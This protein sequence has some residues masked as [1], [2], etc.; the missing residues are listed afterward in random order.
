MSRAASDVQRNSLWGVPVRKLDGDTVWL[1]PEEAMAYAERRYSSGAPRYEVRP[2]P[3][4]PWR[5]E[6]HELS[7]PKD[8]NNPTSCAISVEEMRANVG[9]VKAAVVED[10]DETK[11]NA[12]RARARIK[13]AQIR[14]SQWDKEG[15]GREGYF[16]AVTIVAGKVI[17][18]GHGQGREA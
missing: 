3:L 14:V 18:P 13:R 16:R 6:I 2:D 17:R 9:E 4:R 15:V 11:R 5:D 8:N 7:H 10:A 1:A 12:A